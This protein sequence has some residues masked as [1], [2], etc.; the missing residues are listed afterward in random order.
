VA[1]WESIRILLTIAATYDWELRQIDVKT[2]HLNG[3]LEEE[4]YMRKP[5][6]LGPGFWR[7]LKGLYS[8]KQSGRTWYMELNNKLQTIGL[9]RLESNWSVHICRRNNSQSMATTSVDDMLIGSS[10]VTEANTII[11][12]LSSLFEITENVE[13]KFHLGCTIERWRS[14]RTIKLHQQAYVQSILRDFR[15][16][17]CNSVQT[18]MDPG[19]RLKP[20]EADDNCSE[21]FDYPAFVGK[22]LYLSLCTRPDISYAVRE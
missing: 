19:T 11:A 17:S 12:D 13:P 14:R 21:V 1:R 16:E 3:K 6:I 4:I 18:P 2:A 7:L 15:M 22:V 20:R 8:L 5:D 10:S 9:K